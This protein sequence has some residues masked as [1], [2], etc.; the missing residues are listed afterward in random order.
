MPIVSTNTTSVVYRCEICLT[1][2]TIAVASLVAGTTSSRHDILLPPCVCGAISTLARTFQNALEQ[3]GVVNGLHAHLVS[4]VQ[5]HPSQ[6]A[7]LASETALDKP[8]FF[9][10]PTIATQT[11]TIGATGELGTDMAQL[12]LLK[13]EQESKRLIELGLIVPVNSDPGLSSAVQDLYGVTEE[14]V[15]VFAG[16]KDGRVTA[17]GS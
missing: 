5:T 12:K 16:L 9:V 17:F 3:A 11:M 14:S 15:E 2:D 13:G 8:T 1:D 10:A 4:L 6:A 7:V